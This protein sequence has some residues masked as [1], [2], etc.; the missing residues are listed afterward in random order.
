MVANIIMNSLKSKGASRW[1]V[2][3]KISLVTNKRAKEDCFCEGRPW[4]KEFVWDS[5][6]INL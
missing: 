4:K 2:D 6:K 1:Y 5:K 3:G